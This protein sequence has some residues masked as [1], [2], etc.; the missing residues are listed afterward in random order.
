MTDSTISSSD[1]SE[2]TNNKILLNHNSYSIDRLK[3][4]TNLLIYLKNTS[5][6]GNDRSASSSSSPS[7]NITGSNQERNIYIETK[8]KECLNDSEKAKLGLIVPTNNTCNSN[9]MLSVKMA[10]NKIIEDQETNKPTTMDILNINMDKKYDEL[11]KEKQQQQQ[12][13][14]ETEKQQ[15]TPPLNLLSINDILNS[16][17]SNSKNKTENATISSSSSISFIENKE[18]E[19]EIKDFDFKL[20]DMERDIDLNQSYFLTEQEPQQECNRQEDVTLLQKKTIESAFN[21]ENIDRINSSKLLLSILYSLSEP[22]INNSNN[23]E[24]I[25]FDAINKILNNQKNVELVKC[26]LSNTNVLDLSSTVAQ[27]S[28]IQPSNN[29]NNNNK[30][31]ILK[32]NFDLIDSILRKYDYYCSNSSSS[33]HNYF[34]NRIKLISK[35][36]LNL[37]SSIDFNDLFTNTLT[38]STSFNSYESIQLV[39]KSSSCSNLNNC[40]NKN[41]EKF[42]CNVIKGKKKS[43]LL[44]NQQVEMERE[45]EEEEQEQEESTYRYCIQSI[46]PIIEEPIALVIK[47]EERVEIKN[48]NNI[49]IPEEIR[50]A[51]ASAGIDISHIINLKNH[52]EMSIKNN[53]KPVDKNIEKVVNKDESTFR[54][55]EIKQDISAKVTH[56][57]EKECFSLSDNKTQENDKKLCSKYASLLSNHHEHSKSFKSLT[58]NIIPAKEISS[59]KPILIHKHRTLPT[60]TT[61]S[62]LIASS[63]IDSFIDLNN[64]KS[65]IKNSRYSIDEDESNKTID[66]KTEC[67]SSSDVDSINHYISATTNNNTPSTGLPTSI[68][69]IENMN[70]LA[71]NEQL[72]KKPSVTRSFSY[73]ISKLSTKNLSSNNSINDAL[74]NNINT[75]GNIIINNN[76]NVIG[77]GSSDNKSLLTSNSK[78]LKIISTPTSST[79]GTNLNRTSM[80]YH[81]NINQK[82]LLSTTNSLQS[83]I[84]GFVSSVS[85]SDLPH[86]TSSLI[87]FAT[88]DDGTK[89]LDHIYHVS[90]TFFLKF[91]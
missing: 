16:C 53:D 60:P 44:Y 91:F 28:S 81:Q 58:K 14:R 40:N 51:L 61:I 7:P 2:N 46:N 36:N 3:Q 84:T 64:D 29:N 71:L 20:N 47:E 50:G 88:D 34:R 35:E 31:N 6:L 23:N 4:Y 75:P 38:S 68:S 1:R 54:T 78:H 70:Y 87:K 79:N 82:N 48:E 52:I 26:L 24:Y 5:S 57:V 10:A 41:F 9:N 33:V 37:R 17:Y 18:I 62:H 42:L 89:S 86:S 56:N 73:N 25:Y 45:E 15:T 19:L 83:P 59:F 43:H 8:Y 11:V 69:H 22:N 74:K 76:N 67:V 72:K 77:S 27:Q 90:Y 49:D 55:F 13:D 80:R 65:K 21:N 32:K 66:N 85:T 12:D 63:S 39:K 30:L